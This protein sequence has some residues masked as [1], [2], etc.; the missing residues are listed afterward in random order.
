[1]SDELRAAAERLRMV[2]S[3]KHPVI[4][5]NTGKAPKGF[6]GDW[7]FVRAEDSALASMASDNE[8]LA[9]AYLA[10]HDPTLLDEDWL[11]AV[12][13]RQEDHPMKITFHREDALSVGLWHVDDGWKVMLLHSARSASCVVRGVATRGRF[14]RLADDFSIPIREPAAPAGEV[15]G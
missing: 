10:E 1:M 13:G 5:Y 4:V 14:R 7:N 3:G 11:I 9:D 2:K 8:E 12:G 6:I 15:V